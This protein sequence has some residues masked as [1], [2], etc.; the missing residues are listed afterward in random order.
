[1]HHLMLLHCCILFILWEDEQ[2]SLFDTNYL[3][4]SS[5]VLQWLYIIAVARDVWCDVNI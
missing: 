3:H 2:F 5:S 4:L 1:M